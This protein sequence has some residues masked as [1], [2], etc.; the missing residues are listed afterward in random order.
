MQALFYALNFFLVTVEVLCMTHLANAFF[1]KR[2]ST[3]RHILL[4]LLYILLANLPLLV[5]PA[6]TVLRVS[7]SALL[8]ILWLLLNYRASVFKGL[9]VAVFWL[10]YLTVV[11]ALFLASSSVFAGDAS[12]SL[13]S[14]PFAYYLLCCS[15]KVFEL[16]TVVL[17]HAWVGKRFQ[18][19]YSTWTDWLRVLF[20][21]AA[22]LAAALALVRILY[23]APYLARELFAC[24][25]LLLLADLMAIFLLNYLEHQRQAALENTVLRQN[26]KLEGEHIE[27][28]KAAYAE[29][30]KQT[31]DFQNQL[32]VLQGMA[33]HHAPQEEFS[34]YLETILA[35]SFPATIYVSTNRLV[36]DIVLSQKYSAAKSRG[37]PFRTILDDLADFPLPDDVLVVVL[38]NLIDNAFEACEKLPED[39]RRV[40]LKMQNTEDSAILY[41]ENPTLHPVKIRNDRI[42]T[43]K[44]DPL[45]HG[46]GLKNVC[47]LLDRHNA[48][49]AMRY[50]P[51][52]GVFCFSVQITA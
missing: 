33:E 41:I 17:I 45:A 1:E 39:K 6:N 20:F 34:A 7:G 15:A 3:R 37:I 43:T 50:D 10:S 9:F 32:A 26:L 47:A 23:I 31:H 18:P 2:V 5:F 27:A 35:I 8:A 22:S 21:P 51:A 42:V 24:M 38:T 14:D 44:P 28:L 36:V 48:D 52:A 4:T 49:H 19:P 46:Y 25:F 29:Q 11:D 16:L 12:A 13:L 40:L 30:R